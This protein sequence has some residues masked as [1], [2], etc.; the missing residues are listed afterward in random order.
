MLCTGRLIYSQ[1]SEGDIIPAKHKVTVECARVCVLVFVGQKKNISLK[2]SFSSSTCHSQNFNAFGKNTTPPTPKTELTD[3]ICFAYFHYCL[4]NKEM[5]F[6]VYPEK[7]RIQSV[8]V[9]NY[10]TFVNKMCY[11]CYFI[12]IVQKYSILWALCIGRQR[13]RRKVSLQNVLV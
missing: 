1:E 11:V 6:S 13:P 3:P 9:L 8:C 12:Q 7:N 4:I 10:T 5:I 2:G